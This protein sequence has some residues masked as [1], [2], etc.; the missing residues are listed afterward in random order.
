M[1]PAAPLK[2]AALDA[3]DL[4]VISAHVQDAVLR[5]G[6]LAWS[7]AG[8]RFTVAMNRFAWEAGPA[9]PR[10][11]HIRKRAALHFDRVLSVQTARIRRDAADAV[12]ELLAVGFEAT[13][14]P[15]GIV[16]FVFAGGGAIRLE[17]EC[18][19]AQLADLGGAW[20]TTA[21]PSHDLS[22]TP[23]GEEPAPGRPAR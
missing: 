5:V 12:L 8:H 2:L 4:A 13:D 22:D 15:A 16:T 6:D 7:P 10:K 11:A 19:E 21:V 17:V 9:A 3:E 23:S 20:Q 18:I 1:D 14:A